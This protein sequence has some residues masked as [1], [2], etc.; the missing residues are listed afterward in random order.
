MSEVC[1]YLCCCSSILPSDSMAFLEGFSLEEQLR[2]GRFR[3]ESDQHRDRIARALVR[4]VLAEELDLPPQSLRFVK[5]AHGKPDLDR[6][7]HQIDRAIEFNLSHSGNWVVLAVARERVG[8]DIENIERENNVLAIADRYFFGEELEELYSFPLLEQRKRFFDYWTLKEAYMKAR[9]EGIS[10]GLSH[11]GF[12]VLGNS[13]TI[14]MTEAIK[15]NPDQ[16]Q[17][18]CSPLPQSNR[19]LNSLLSA[20]C[21]NALAELKSYQLAIALNTPDRFTVDWQLRTPFG[22]STPLYNE[23]NP[24]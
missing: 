10:L 16:W 6:A 12:S 3:F 2:N 13:I 22:V 1:V 14:H 23:V 21:P 8:I 7:F 5:G 9:G 18:L 24:Q 20:Q 19:V 4:E 11:F 15:D 17:F